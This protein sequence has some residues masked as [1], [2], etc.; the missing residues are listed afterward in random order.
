V[1]YNECS[2]RLAAISVSGMTSRRLTDDYL[3]ALGRTV[4]E[5]LSGVMAGTQSS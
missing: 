2:E 1:V 3:P 5:V 4:R